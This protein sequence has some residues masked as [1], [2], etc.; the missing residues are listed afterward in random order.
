LPAAAEKATATPQYGAFALIVAIENYRDLPP[1]IGA[2]VDADNYR[3][4]A[5]T[6]LGI[7]PERIRSAV[8]SRATK[9]DIERHLDWLRD[10]VTAGSRV[11][12][13][14]SGHGAP[15]PSTGASYLVPFDADSNALKRSALPL[16][17]LLDTL[18]G[19]RA[20]E[21]VAFVD[22]CFSGEGT[23]SLLPDGARPLV[24]V[25]GSSAPD[26]VALFTAVTGNEIAGPAD[27]KQGGLFS[28]L[29][30]NGL[31]GGAAD[32]DGDGQLTAGELQ[33]WLQPRVSR[34]AR[35]AG[36]TQS[37]ALQ[38]G[39]SV[40]SADELP[41][42]WGLHGEAVQAEASRPVVARE[43][44]GAQGSQG[45]DRPPTV[46]L[47]IANAHPTTLSPSPAPQTHPFQ[48]DFL[49]DFLELSKRAVEL[50]ERATRPGA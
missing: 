30:F 29:V 18:S 31:A 21:V 42:L 45:S 17:D 8:G 2:A 33:R 43:V 36:R 41:L 26:K 25:K 34:A 35:L 24:A 6:T 4:L 46:P 11:Y 44:F 50:C 37:P 5:L 20:K 28:S 14:Y 13:F 10:N 12:F 38:L 15:D 23:R 48:G 9:A 16:S 49:E 32:A 7:P 39:R 19:T 22:A 1:A 47:D 40:A 3:S 27:R